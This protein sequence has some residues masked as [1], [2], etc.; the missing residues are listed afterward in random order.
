MAWYLYLLAI[1]AGTLAGFINT[2][3]GSGSLI[4]LPFLI[5]L[6][7]PPTVANGTNRIGV[8]FQTMV[9]STSFHRKGVLDWRA[10]LILAIPATF[11]S[12]LGAR[13]A[14][15]IDEEMMQTVIGVVMVIMLMIIIVRPNRW[16]EGSSELLF[17][18]P[19]IKEIL[20]FFAI[21]VY[22]GFIQAGVGIFLLAGLVLGVGYDLVRA[23]AVKSLII[24]IFTVAAL[25]V[26]VANDQV[27]WSLG[28]LMAVGQMIGGWLGATFAVEKGAVW[29]RRLLIVVV[30]VAAAQLLGLTP[31]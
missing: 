28:L 14:V 10:G 12:I 26:F 4:T 31:F 7:L 3:A 21:G 22:G 27:V 11:G 18:R 20:L 29:V 15:D 17:R 13:I 2:L 16:L 5:F 9:S 6:G 30:A 19:G 25:A 24:M 23:N 1:L 8:L